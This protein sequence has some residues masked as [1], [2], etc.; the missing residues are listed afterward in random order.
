[1][2]IFSTGTMCVK[3]ETCYEKYQQKKDMKTS[4]INILIKM[5]NV[6]LSRVELDGVK[7][8]RWSVENLVL[9]TSKHSPPRKDQKLNSIEVARFEI[10]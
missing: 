7:V 9:Q 8:T 3:S 4:Y 10:L 1:M 5:P 2:A 6:V